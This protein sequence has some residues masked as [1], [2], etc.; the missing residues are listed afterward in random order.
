MGLCGPAS[1][2]MTQRSA[3]STWVNAGATFVALI[4]AGFDLFLL[5]LTFPTLAKELGLTY[6]GSG[7]LM[8]STLVGM[9]LGGILTVR[10]CDRLGRVRAS[11][12][13]LVMLSAGTGI[14][15]LTH[16]Y[17]LLA[18]L[19]LVSGLGIGGIY[20]VGNL[21]ASET[22]PTRIRTTALAL[23]QSGWSVGYVLAS[24]FSAWIVPA[25]GWR[26][27]HACSVGFG[28]LAI[29]LGFLVQ[30]RPSWAAK[31]AAE[32]PRWRDKYGEIWR[33]R[34]LRWTFVIWTFTSVALQLAYYGAI[35]WLPSYLASELRF[36]ARVVGWYLA[37]ASAA[38]IV[39]KAAT[40]FLADAVGRGLMWLVVG[41][42]T[43][44]ALPLLVY[45]GPSDSLLYMLLVV[46]L[47]CAAPYAINST[48]LN[49]SFPTSVRGT[50]VAT[51]YS[52]G[53]LSATAAPLLVGWAATQH[54]IG[55]G[56]ALLGIPYAV[57]AMLAGLGIRE[58]MYDPHA[59]ARDMRL[60][61]PARSSTHEDIGNP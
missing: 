3:S 2:C 42:G 40:G 34:S 53:S 28:I 45:S 57:S 60:V 35:A 6:V 11:A 10:L 8:A 47:F 31:V 56:I 12:V 50:A 23:L 5:P 4:A 13:S 43:S 59:R 17:W 25:Y 16:S 15:A 51:S 22:V 1:T 7:G 21:L 37:A 58:K 54:S 44:L 38:M 14:G 41:V 52:L 27:L 33:N 20:C 26:P 18:A 55:L 48:H 9:G 29:L 49:E 32:R 19:R 39:G 24:A 36:D 61:T 46:G 30:E